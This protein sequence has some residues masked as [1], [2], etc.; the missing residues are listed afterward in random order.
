MVTIAPVMSEA[1]SVARVRTDR[2]SMAEGLADE[3]EEFFR[4]QHPRLVAIALA[5]TGDLEVARD[6]AQEGLLRAY[7]D[8]SKVV[9]LE[10]P[11]AWVRRV[12]VNLAIDGRRRRARDE[13]VVARLTDRRG[14]HASSSEHDVES[15]ATWQAVRELPERQRAAVVLRY[16]DDLAVSEIA[17]ILRV[18]DGT[19]KAS[20]HTARTALEKRLG[21]ED[22]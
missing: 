17:S 20:L 6:A 11:F 5:L 14:G 9:E 7:R 18:T 1:V 22:R 21:R 10:L 13:R 15:S 2:G 12:V 8:W 16:V 19:V 3:F 4:T